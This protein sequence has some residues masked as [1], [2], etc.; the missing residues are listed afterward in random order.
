MT[1]THR[2][3]SPGDHYGASYGARR[4]ASDIRLHHALEVDLPIFEGFR[5]RHFLHVG[6]QTCFDALVRR[7]LVVSPDAPVVLVQDMTLPKDLATALCFRN[8]LANFIPLGVDA[9]H[10][11]AAGT[12]LC[13]QAGVFA[14]SGRAGVTA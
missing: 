7:L 6:H 9:G 11:T 13:V 4:P 1:L 8:E 10:G 14:A 3:A 2:T 12:V 5:Q